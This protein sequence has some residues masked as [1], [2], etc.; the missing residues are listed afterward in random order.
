LR[1]E[2]VPLAPGQPELGVQKLDR[3]ENARPDP[4]FVLRVDLPR[5]GQRGLP[6]REL[7]LRLDQGEIGVPGARRN[8]QRGVAPLR[9]GRLFCVRRNG[10]PP[11]GDLPAEPRQEGLRQGQGELGPGEPGSRALQAVLEEEVVEGDARRGPGTQELIERDVRVEKP[12]FY[13]RGGVRNEAVILLPMVEKCVEPRIVD[14]PGAEDAGLRDRGVERRNA[15]PEVPLDGRAHRRIERDGDLPFRG[16]SCARG[17]G[18]QN[19]E[20]EEQGR[21]P[22]GLHRRSLIWPFPG[23]SS[24]RGRRLRCAWPSV[25]SPPRRTGRPGAASR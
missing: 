13:H 8:G 3:G 10:D 1:L 20:E 15:E 4:R 23:A 2:Q 24:P 16:V 12:A 11:F 7:L 17:G 22:A 9:Q 25:R 19:R 14:T 18:N 21:P 5:D 6:G